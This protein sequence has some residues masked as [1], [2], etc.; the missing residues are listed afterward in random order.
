[1]LEKF[2]DIDYSEIIKNEGGQ[3]FYWQSWSIKVLLKLEGA[4]QIYIK[5]EPTIYQPDLMHDW[6]RLDHVL[7]RKANIKPTYRHVMTSSTKQIGSPVA[8]SVACMIWI[9]NKTVPPNMAKKIK[10]Y[11]SIVYRSLNYTHFQFR[12]YQYNLKNGA[13]Q[14]NC[15]PKK[16]MSGRSYTCNCQALLKW[17]LWVMVLNLSLFQGGNCRLP[18]A[19]VKTTLINYLNHS[20]EKRAFYFL[21]L[22]F[23]SSSVMPEP[24]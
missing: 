5:N 13:A 23:V 4:V 17:F 6:G 7:W 2:N 12:Q 18:A 24:V 22:S 1:M 8:C 15:K 11:P 9:T 19:S 20:C 21:G 3:C 14:F 16:H 10:C